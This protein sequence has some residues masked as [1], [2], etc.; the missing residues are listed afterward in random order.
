MLLG[1][2]AHPG[3]RTDADRAAVRLELAGHQLEEHRLARA[4]GTDQ[5][6][7]LAVPHEQVDVRRGAECTVERHTHAAELEGLLAAAKAVEP[8]LHGLAL[9]HGLHDLAALL[10]PV[11]ALAATS[12]LL[13]VA[14]VHHQ[15]RPQLEARDL[16]L[17]PGD[18]LLLVGVVLLLLQS[19]ELPRVCA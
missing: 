6:H 8:Q 5:T 14:R 12:R 17:D 9:A 16:R 18:L 1:V 3:A 7:A 15:A 11:E 4:V 19:L 2:V 10:H 13:H